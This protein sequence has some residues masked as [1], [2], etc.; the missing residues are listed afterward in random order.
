MGE[1]MS[2]PMLNNKKFDQFTI[3]L[4]ANQTDFDFMSSPHV[5]EFI[6]TFSKSSELNIKIDQQKQCKKGDIDWVNE[7][8]LKAFEKIT[9]VIEHFYFERTLI[10]FINKK[11]PNRDKVI[12][13][14]KYLVSKVVK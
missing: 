3:N 5:S 6:Q 12:A 14:M 13:R 7:H 1:A 11:H 4:V 2:H 9:I 10:D 8:N